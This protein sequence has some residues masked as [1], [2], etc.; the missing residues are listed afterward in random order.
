MSF[1][2]DVDPIGRPDPKLRLI[3]II[4][5]VL[6][7]AALL[8]FMYGFR[9][10]GRKYTTAAWRTHTV[11]EPNINFQ[12]ST[13]GSLMSIYQNMLFDGEPAT[14]KVFVGSDMGTDFSITIA[15]RPESDQRTIEQMSK[16]LLGVQGIQPFSGAGGARAVLTDF[17]LDDKRT[18]A[19]VIFKDRMLYQLMASGPAKTFPVQ[20]ADRFF[21]S[22]KLG[23]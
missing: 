7:A 20:Q 23:D 9:T 19:R 17:V 3:A 12:V 13:P 18:Q 5:V 16:T 22:F 6:I 14:A 1:D 10:E 8:A 11:S 4:P 2:D 15:E 21:A